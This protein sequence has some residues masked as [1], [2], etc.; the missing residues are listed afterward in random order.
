MYQNVEKVKVSEY[1]PNALSANRSRVCV[2]H[3]QQ[4]SYICVHDIQFPWHIVRSMDG[5]KLQ[6]FMS[7]MKW[8]WLSILTYLY[9]VII[10]NSVSKASSHCCFTC[11]VSLGKASINTWYSLEINLKGLS[12]CLKIVLIFEASCLSSVCCTEKMKS[13]ICNKSPQLPHGLVFPGYLT[14]IETLV[15]IWSRSDEAWQR[16]TLGYLYTLYIYQE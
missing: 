5:L 14:L 10:I 12:D 15:T 1:F 4:N 2:L 16:I 9:P 8:T 7:E 6:S 11:F 3:L 13:C